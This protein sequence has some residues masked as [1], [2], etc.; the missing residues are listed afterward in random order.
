MGI[1][2]EVAHFSGCR[3]KYLRVVVACIP[4]YISIHTIVIYLRKLPDVSY[5]I[6]KSPKPLVSCAMNANSCLANGDICKIVL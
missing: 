3:D 2:W 4:T 6:K 5:R 1:G